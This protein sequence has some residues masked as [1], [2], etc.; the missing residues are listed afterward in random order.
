MTKENELRFVFGR[1]QWSQQICRQI[2]QMKNVLPVQ[3]GIVE[4][5]LQRKLFHMHKT[6]EFN[7]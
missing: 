3:T 6:R 7:G 5:R 2:R 1:R 4:T